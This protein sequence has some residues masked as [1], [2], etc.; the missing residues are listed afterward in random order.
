MKNTW[1]YNKLQNYLEDVG[2]Q[3]GDNPSNFLEVLFTFIVY[4]FVGAALVIVWA[5][6]I[7]LFPFY[8]VKDFIDLYYYINAEKIAK[9]KAFA[10]L[11]EK[12]K[13]VE[14]Y[15]KEYSNYVKDLRLLSLKK[16]EN[17]KNRTE[18]NLDI[19]R[20][21]DY[22]S[23]LTTPIGSLPGS[24]YYNSS[25]NQQF[26][27]LEVEKERFKTNLER[28]NNRYSNSYSNSIV[29]YSSNYIELT[30]E[31]VNKDNKTYVDF[32]KRF[33]LDYN[34]THVTIVETAKQT[35]QC[36][37]Q[38]RRSARDIFLI[39]KSYYPE[40]TFAEVFKT[41]VNLVLDKTVNTSYCSNVRTYVYYP[42]VI[43]IHNSYEHKLEFHTKLNYID[44][45][46]Y[47][48]NKTNG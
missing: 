42:D 7:L 20:L 24:R 26:A 39:T 46:N 16:L 1:L 36:S 45:I 3:G 29:D 22:E 2:I 23:Y 10:E 14:D 27:D 33:L 38:R 37:K 30:Q 5:S 17:K 35:I 44:I 41:L 18:I 48:K 11:I 32:I 9:K 4:P 6:S 19:E 21:P 8:L 34:M 40:V 47:F 43:S 12:N 25:F 31:E 15:I 28:L 13:L